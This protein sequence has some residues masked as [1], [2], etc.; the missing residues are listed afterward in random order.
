MIALFFLHHKVLP[1]I[2][3][4]TADFKQNR[5]DLGALGAAVNDTIA[6]LGHLPG[7]HGRK[8]LPETLPRAEIIRDL[9]KEEKYA[10][11]GR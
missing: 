2:R 3:L 6:V 5:G 8:S 11:A 4:P 9:T 10:C 7:K 1:R